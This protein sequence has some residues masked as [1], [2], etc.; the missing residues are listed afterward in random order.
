MVEEIILRP[1]TLADAKMLARLW[2]VT[3]P[4]KFGPILGDKSERIIC[5]WLQLSEH[6]LPTTT[7]AEVNGI[8]I[9][10]MI[11]ETP[12]TPRPQSGPWLWRALRLHNGVLGALRS[13][14]LMV[15]I[16]S[17]RRL[18]D[19]EVYISMLGVAP[20]WRREGLAAQL[21]THAESVAREATANRLTLNVMSDNKTAIKLYK[22]VGFEIT[23]EKR[24]RFLKW[25]TGHNGYYE[26]AKGLRS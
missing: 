23:I 20:A 24:S 4:D 11:L 7:V 2:V 19:D 14:V 13:F 10:F 1:A 8:V 21:I 6:H 5:D 9:G 3:F 17:D 16:D 15:L 12:A 22:K 26:M 25:I 18:G